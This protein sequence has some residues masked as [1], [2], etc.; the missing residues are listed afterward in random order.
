VVAA[1]NAVVEPISVTKFKANGDASKNQEHLLIKN[2]PAVT[3]V[4]A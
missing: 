3:M 4:A 2:T 1:K